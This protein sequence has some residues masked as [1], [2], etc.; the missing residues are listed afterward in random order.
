MSESARGPLPVLPTLASRYRTGLSAMGAVAFLVFATPSSVTI[1]WG[2]V[3]ILMGEVL[4]VWASGHIVKNDGITREGP[5]S[6]S[7]NPLYV[8]NFIIGTGFVVAAGNLWIA[9]FFL[10][11]FAVLYSFTISYEEQ[12]LQMMF[13]EEWESYRKSVPRFFSLGVLPNY[14]SGEFT[15]ELVVKHREVRNLPAL[16]IA[17]VILWLKYVLLR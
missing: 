15:W 17:A 10:V 12:F 9:P 13:P 7:R 5:Y 8:G 2:I 1:K 3:I 6:L 4:R 14:V 11:F 16:L